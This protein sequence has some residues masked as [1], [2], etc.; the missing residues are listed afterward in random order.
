MHETV[1]TKPEF[2]ISVMRRMEKLRPTIESYQG[3]YSDEIS[4]SS[5]KAYNENFR[6]MRESGKLP[7]Q[8]GSNS[9]GSYWPYRT[10]LSRGMVAMMLETYCAL[11]SQG[12]AIS[13]RRAHQMISKIEVCLQVL[14]LYPPN[15]VSEHRLRPKP[16]DGNVRKGKRR[17]LAGLGTDWRQK[18][19]AALPSDSRFTD[20]VL[21][22]I[23][24]GLRPSELVKGVL[25]SAVS[26]DKLKIEIS[27]AKVTALAG[28]QKRT[29]WVKVDNPVALRLFGYLWAGRGTGQ[30]SVSIDDP[31]KFCDEVRAFCAKLFPNTKYKAS[32]YSFRHSFASD[33]KDMKVSPSRIAQMM[34]HASER[35]QRAYGVSRHGRAPLVH[36]DKVTATREVRAAN[37]SSASRAWMAAKGNFQ[38]RNQAP[39]VQK[40]SMS[41]SILKPF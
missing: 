11:S 18:V 23:L 21:V 26:A 34:G 17:G 22:L 27:G 30:I 36:V 33:L 29:L 4:A 2:P 6:R 13:P 40:T 3:A 14:I 12:E 15:K 25:V 32:P 8:F 5:K 7:S 35:S 37:V 28:Q 9:D 39:S 24:T 10:A 16:A 41:R 1:P 19:A 20:A 38:A 31:R